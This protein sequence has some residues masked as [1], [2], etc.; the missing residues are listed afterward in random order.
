VAK[1]GWAS[2]GSEIRSSTGWVGASAA[3]S[4]SRCC[5]P[6]R[7][8]SAIGMAIAL[9][10]RRRC[11]PLGA[12]PTG[13]G[14]TMNRNPISLLASVGTFAL[15]GAVAHADVQRDISDYQSRAGELQS[16]PANPKHPAEVRAMRSLADVLSA[17][18]SSCSDCND[19]AAAIR[20]DA[21]LIEL[22]P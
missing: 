15:F 13:G 18:P 16:Q 22:S 2:I 19:A 17:M 8:G 20:E 10:G 9:P 14:E 4:A 5:L 11:V 3:P 12:A 6:D 1:A 21:R 7:Q